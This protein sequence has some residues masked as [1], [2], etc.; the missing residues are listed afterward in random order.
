MR[1][2]VYVDGL[3]LFY[4]VLKGTQFKWLDLA[5]YF[6]ALRQKDEVVE[7]RYFTARFEGTRGANQ[8]AYLQALSST[9]LV[10]V[11]FGRFQSEKY[12]CTVPIPHCTASFRDFFT[13]KEKQTDVGLAV[14]MV[15]DAARDRMD[16]AV[17]ISGDSDLVPG[18][19]AVQRFDKTT[20]LYVPFKEPKLGNYASELRTASGDDRLFPVALLRVCQFPDEVI[21]ARG[22]VR[23]PAG[24]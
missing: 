22:P 21:S 16:A 23:K 2:I 14:A 11:D 15:E 3:N 6:V 10:R 9:P 20:I 18:V 4:G 17:V 7:V 24:W 13:T 19:R 8:S 1:V 5:K 12:E